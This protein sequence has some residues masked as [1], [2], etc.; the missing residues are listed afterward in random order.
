[1]WIRVV[2]SLFTVSSHSS[3]FIQKLI[4]RADARVDLAEFSTEHRMKISASAA[5][6]HIHAFLHPQAVIVDNSGIEDIFLLEGFKTTSAMLGVTLI[7]LPKDAAQ[8]LMWLTKLDS[9]SLSGT[10]LCFKIFMPIC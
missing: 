9:W 1:M 8:N 2:T 6:G 7:E 4:L 3:T 5:L 10:S